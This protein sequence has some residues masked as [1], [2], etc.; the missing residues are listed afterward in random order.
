[1]QKIHYNFTPDYCDHFETSLEAYN[2]ILQVL[3]QISKS[4]SKPAS[5]LVIFDPYFCAGTMKKLLANLGFKN[6]INENNDFYKT[7]SNN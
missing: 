3:N 7:I 4:I 1:M 6:V 5:S 2:D